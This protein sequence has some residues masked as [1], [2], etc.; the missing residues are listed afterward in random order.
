MID[1]AMQEV[2]NRWNH[3]AE[4]RPSAP[5]SKTLRM[6]AGALRIEFTP[7][8][9][10][11]DADV[12]TARGRLSTAL[13]YAFQTA[14]AASRFK[15]AVDSYA[16]TKAE[17]VKTETALA[18]AKARLAANV[19]DKDL[20]RDA[21]IESG[22]LASL[23]SMYAER[24][25]ALKETILSLKEKALQALKRA[26]TAA[27]ETK[28]PVDNDAAFNAVVEA[29]KDAAGALAAT[30]RDCWKELQPDNAA[31][32]AI[33]SLLP[34][35]LR[36]QGYAEPPPESQAK[37]VPPTPDWLMP[38]ASRFPGFEVPAQGPP[39]DL[40]PTESTITH[41]HFGDPRP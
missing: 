5:Y 6:E 30:P 14:P 8:D 19:M 21:H 20:Y 27:V 39:V 38:G 18:D 29:V 35:D 22:R 9:E 15:I 11:S 36:P 33:L 25:T 31:T 34:A 1:Y 2:A 16:Q 32:N 7:D 23:I 24:L 26:A 10:Q 17:M 13:A 28:P 40:A 4:S 37:E 41:H 12:A 3:A